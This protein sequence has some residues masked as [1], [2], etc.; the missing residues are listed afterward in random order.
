MLR[1]AVSCPLAHCLNLPAAVESSDQAEMRNPALAKVSNRKR[2]RSCSAR[3]PGRLGASA[4]RPGLCGVQG[5]PFRQPPGQK[6]GGLGLL[7][8]CFCRDVA[9]LAATY[10]REARV[11]RLKNLG[12]MISARR[13]TTT[14]FLSPTTP[15]SCFSFSWFLGFFR[16]WVLVDIASPAALYATNPVSTDNNNTLPPSTSDIHH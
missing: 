8:C 13:A 14:L 10:K 12:C 11:D 9:P 15:L 1:S 7:L 16:I 4:R 3:R 2:R 5:R 6:G